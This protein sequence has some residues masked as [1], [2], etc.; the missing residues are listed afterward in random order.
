MCR[1]M[2]L[3]FY[4]YMYVYVHHVCMYWGIHVY[5]MV[6]GV[7]AV[8]L[9]TAGCIRSTTS[10]AARSTSRS[11]A[12]SSGSSS[13]VVIAVVILTLEAAVVEVPVH[14]GSSSHT[15]ASTSRLLN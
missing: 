6:A 12:R 14:D 5:M 4:M 3:Y 10:T 1:H 8:A 13:V 2:H 15:Y 9:A 7:V 11:A